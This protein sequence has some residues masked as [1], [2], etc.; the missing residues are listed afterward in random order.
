MHHFARFLDS[1]AI[2]LK[3]L[4]FEKPMKKRESKQKLLPMWVFPSCCIYSTEP[5]LRIGTPLVFIR[6]KNHPTD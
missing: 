6:F 3:T 4:R 5:E 2:L 1:A